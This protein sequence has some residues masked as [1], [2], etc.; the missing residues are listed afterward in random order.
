MSAPE[1]VEQTP[2]P[3]I[4]VVRGHPTPVQVAALTAVLAGAAG[5]GSGEGTGRGATDG[6]PGSLWTARP[7]PSVGPGGWR[8]S[9]MPR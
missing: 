9:S 1:D 3:V 7:R 4:R 8:A 2:A 5:G 6:S